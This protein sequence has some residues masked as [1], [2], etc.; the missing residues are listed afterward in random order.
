MKSLFVAFTG[1]RGKTVLSDVL[2]YF[3]FQLLKNLIIYIPFPQCAINTLQ[4]QDGV[5]F[6]CALTSDQ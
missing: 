6:Y 3:Y 1:R 2:L 4:S 5:A